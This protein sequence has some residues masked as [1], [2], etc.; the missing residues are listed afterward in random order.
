MTLHH[1]RHHHYHHWFLWLVAAR[2]LSSMGVHRLFVAVAL[3]L[4]LTTLAGFVLSPLWAAGTGSMFV[5]GAI[6]WWAAT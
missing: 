1:H 5:F 6:V 3:A 4:V 2:V